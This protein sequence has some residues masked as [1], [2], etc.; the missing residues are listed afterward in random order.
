MQIVTL[1]NFL[2]GI[3]QKGEHHHCRDNAG[4]ERGNRRTGNSK[5]EPQISTAFPAIFNP[6]ETTAIVIGSLVFP[7][8][9]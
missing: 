7:C 8:A 2:A 1:R 3:V 9:R 6:L 5:M 4:T